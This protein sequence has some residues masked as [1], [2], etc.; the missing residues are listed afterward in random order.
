MILLRTINS[1][2]PIEQEF[3]VEPRNGELRYSFIISW[4]DYREKLRGQDPLR[5]LFKYILSQLILYVE[6]ILFCEPQAREVQPGQSHHSIPYDLETINRYRFILKNTRK[7]R[8]NNLN[9]V[10]QINELKSQLRRNPSDP[11]VKI[12]LDQIR[13]LFQSNIAAFEQ[14]RVGLQEQPKQI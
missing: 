8:E 14:M 5:K 10:Q 6:I 12:E 9:I 3:F 7:F 1:K 4:K 11:N 13:I 2:I